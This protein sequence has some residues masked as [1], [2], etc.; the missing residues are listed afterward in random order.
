MAEH[1]TSRFTEDEEAVGTDAAP[2]SPGMPAAPPRKRRA[3]IVAAVFF[4]AMVGL[5]ALPLVSTVQPAYYARYPGLQERMDNWRVSTH[6]RMSCVSCH[7]HPGARGLLSFAARSIPAFYVQLVWGPHETNLLEPPDRTAC[8]KCH[9]S[10]RQVSAD[11]DLLIP[12]RAHVEILEIECVV[13]HSELVHA[14]S[15]E[16][17]NRPAMKMCLEQCHDGEIAG[18]ECVKCHTRKHV[19]EDHLRTDWLEIHAEMVDTIECGECHAWTSDY[20]G[21]CHSKRPVTHVGNWKEGH[22]ERARTHAA[23]C[24]VCHSQESCEECH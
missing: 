13:C 8:Q 11:G 12:H 23:G 15:P 10:Y 18:D 6:G 7:V 9:T 19:P 14:E 3:R 21:D 4:A 2:G 16:G 1:E 24:M 17:F 5:L 22:A 20:C